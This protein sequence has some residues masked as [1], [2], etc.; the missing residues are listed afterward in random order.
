MRGGIVN[1]SHEAVKNFFRGQRG[2]KKLSPEITQI[3]GLC[4]RS[5]VSVALFCPIFEKTEPFVESYCV[6][7][8]IVLPLMPIAK[9]ERREHEALALRILAEADLHAHLAH[10]LLLDD[11]LRE[12]APDLANALIRSVVQFELRRKI[13][14]NSAD[15]AR[16]VYIGSIPVPALIA[17]LEPVQPRAR[18]IVDVDNR[19][20]M[21][22]HA[23]RR[24]SRRT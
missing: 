24:R 20:L 17:I 22:D 13:I 2:D 18:A 7:E 19:L 3:S 9:A 21:C 8:T 12:H 15:R 16:C 14:A 11:R 10:I 1:I 23:L 4:I 6:A 5:I